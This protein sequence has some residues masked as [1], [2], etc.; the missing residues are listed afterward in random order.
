M[1]KQIIRRTPVADQ[2]LPMNL[3]PVVRQ[4]YASR[5]V[6]G[7]HE[8]E[9]TLK[10]I[11]PVTSLSGLAAGCDI[12]Y[13]ALQ[14]SKRI[15]IV[16]DF[17]ADGATSTALMMEA[18]TLLGSRTHNFIVPNRFEYGYGLSPEIVEIAHQQ[19]AEL[20]IT[21]DNGI[22]CFAG[23]ERA[24]SLGMKV[25]VTDHHLP[26]E[27][28]PPADAII[29][30]NQYDCQ[31]PSKALAGVGVAFYFMLALRK[32]LRDANWFANQQ[33]P[34]PNL[35]QLLDLVALGTVADVVPLD[36]N[37]RILVAQ[38]LKR[39]RAGFTRPGIQALIEIAKRDQTKL[40]AADFGFALGP[41][42]NAAG[43][44]DD[45]S[46]G[47]NCLLA[48]DLMEARVMASELDELNK[49]RRE[50]E[51]GMQVEAERVL[52]SLKFSEDNLPFAIALFQ[53]DWHQGV[54]G[55]VAGRL[56]E[57][58]HR[59]SIVFAAADADSPNKDG[60]FDNEQE[61]K[62]S[63]RSIPGLH[64]RD[65]LEH[66]DS[67]HPNIIIKFGGH[68]MAAGLS[69]QA[70]NFDQF[71][72]LFS[73]YAEAWLDKEQLT[74]TLLSDG[75]LPA[76]LMTIEFADL[77]QEAGPWGQQFPEPMFDDEFELLQ[78]RIVGEKHLKLVVQKDN[79]AFDA[80]AFNIDVK[81]WP[82]SQ[83]KKAHIAY[84]LSVNEFRGKQNVQLMVEHLKAL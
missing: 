60:V 66:I 12:L 54:I 32:L 64:I 37:N 45:M 76:S 10:Q 17:D 78:Q 21:V 23:I 55:I 24:Q 22:S 3:H 73:Q 51:Q 58:F 35:A 70:K 53:K 79:V 41:R 68:A 44:L 1:Q 48:N 33:I 13:Q 50:I 82:N 34:E 19:G 63:A 83:A 67:Q 9:L 15:T 40:V 56:K 52:A 26:G 30:P 20:I 80:I 69:I 81:A 46:Y 31:F 8:L 65:L 61:I 4:L 14:T 71:N 75:E 5:G 11:A 16:G 72:Q 57:K 38:G 49:A 62:G 59:P 29:N 7:D 43:R 39:I 27:R 6:A 2:H 25:I 77:L 36:A 74:G 42:I 18:L 47:I 84:K 28:L